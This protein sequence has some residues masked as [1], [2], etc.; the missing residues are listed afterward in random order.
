MS[1]TILVVI[2]LIVMWFVVLVPMFVRRHDESTE[3]RS[4]DRFATAMRVVSR[5]SRTTDP[6][7][8][9]PR[10]E[11]M[12]PTSATAARIRADG[13]RRMMARRRRTLATLTGLMFAVLGGALALAAWLWT[14]TTVAGL[15]LAGYLGWLRQQASR[16]RARAARRAAV[17]SRSTPSQPPHL[18]RIAAVAP[19]VDTQSP[20]AD[21]QSPVAPATTRR[22]GRVIRPGWAT[23]KTVAAPPA[24][25][26]PAA[27]AE[28]TGAWQPTPVPL[29]TYVT[30][31]PSF[32]GTAVGLDDDDPMFSDIDAIIAPVDRRRAAN[33]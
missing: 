25:T 31:A 16:Q 5:R 15:L 27:A 30:K 29:P 18:A 32:P 1:S 8:S 33:E 13:R 24:A 6:G 28:Y 17:F 21:T 4:M 3:T 10:A 23:R 22:Y 20:V 26:A 19:A 7:L 12:P 14:V 2:V 11:M 9:R